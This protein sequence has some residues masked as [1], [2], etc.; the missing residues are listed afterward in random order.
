MYYVYYSCASSI[1]DSLCKSDEPIISTTPLQY[2]LCRQYHLPQ[3]EAKLASEAICVL[4]DEF[5][6]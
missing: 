4:R 1:D 6:S 2:F 3:L 5:V